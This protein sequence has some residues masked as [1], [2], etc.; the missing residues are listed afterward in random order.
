MMT[1]IIR[2]CICKSS[3][4]ENAIDL[5]TKRLFGQVKSSDLDPDVAMNEALSILYTWTASLTRTTI[6]TLRGCLRRFP[7]GQGIDIFMITLDIRHTLN[8]IKHRLESHI[9]RASS[10]L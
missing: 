10:S 6:A 1:V 3:W 5:S 8:K 4:A 9:S 7:S 2:S